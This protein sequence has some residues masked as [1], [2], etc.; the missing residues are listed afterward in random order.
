[1][2]RRRIDA[3][4]AKLVAV[5]KR[6]ASHLDLSRPDWNVAKSRQQPF[7]PT[8]VVG[9]IV[10]YCDP[11]GTASH[12]RLASQAVQMSVDWRARIDDP[13]GVAADQP[14]VR[15]IKRER[16][17]IVGPHAFDVELFE[18]LHSATL[19][20]ADARPKSVQV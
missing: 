20:C 8:A 12:L 6:H 1:M 13:A 4:G 19:H 15:S 3:Q 18:Q 14:A 9:V 7:K 16:A 5:G 11:S 10:R 2:A 17:G